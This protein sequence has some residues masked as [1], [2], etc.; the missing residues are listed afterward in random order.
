MLVVA[1]AGHILADLLYAVP[2]FVIGGVLWYTARK[3]RLAGD[4]DEYWDGE[5]DPQWRDDPRLKD[6]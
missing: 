1:H 2:M 5:D 3:E 4:H 6:D